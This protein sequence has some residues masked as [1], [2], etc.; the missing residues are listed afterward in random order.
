[1]KQLKLGTKLLIGGLLTVAIPIVV[2]GVVAVY[3]STQSITEL[4]RSSMGNTAQSLARGLDNAFHEQ[5]VMVRNIS[6]SS[7]V[8]AA[9]EKVAREGAKN[10]QKEI[11]LAQIELTKIKEPEAEHLSS[12][13][14]VGKNGTTYASCDN[15]KFKGLN[16]AGRD[17]LDT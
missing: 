5:L 14:L 2:I 4:A 16:L 8:I 13:M 15:G 11:L 10:S 3:Q 9:A 1:M 12:I 7:S 17:Y 6:Y